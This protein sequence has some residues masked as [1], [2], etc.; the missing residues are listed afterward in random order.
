MMSEDDKYFYGLS[1]KQARNSFGKR[2]LDK[3]SERVYDRDVRLKKKEPFLTV[4]EK[5][6]MEFLINSILN[7]KKEAKA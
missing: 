3:L 6:E 4:E 5:Y 1:S 2:R 7:E